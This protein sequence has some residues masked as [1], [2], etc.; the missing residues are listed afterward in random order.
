MYQS[1]NFDRFQRSFANYG[2][3]DDFTYEGI[4]ALF[5]ILK[6]WRKA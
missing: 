6:K 1:I 5:I 2:C 3:S 4:K